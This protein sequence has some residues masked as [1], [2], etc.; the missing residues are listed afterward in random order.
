[1][2]NSIKVK[3]NWHLNSFIYHFFRTFFPINK[4]RII[5]ESEGDFTDNA[6]ALF[7]Y[8]Y[9][10]GYFNNTYQAF[11]LMDNPKHFNK[12]FKHTKILNKTMKKFNF[13]LM[14]YLA[15]S[16]DYIYDH[17]NLFENFK[18][19]P[20]QRI[21]YL[22]HGFGYKAPKGYIFPE[23]QG[24]KPDV[25]M[26]EGKIPAKE[27]S[28]WY[29]IDIKKTVQLGYPRNDY[30]LQNNSKIYALFCNDHYHFNTYNKVVLWMPTFRQSNI[31][32]L[33]ENY[34]SAGTGLPLLTSKEKL[35]EFNT[36]LK[37]K[38]VLLILKMHHLQANLEVF[39]EQFSNIIVIRDELFKK[40]G[41]QLY[42]F[43]SLADAL[44]TDYSSIS[45][46]FLL[47]D[48]PIIYTLDDYKE[49]QKSRGI[50]P[51]NALDLMRGY[52]VY[53]ITDL[54]IAINDIIIGKD[55]YKDDRNK[56]M[57]SL[58]EYPDGKASK[59]IVDYLGYEL[60]K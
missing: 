49:Y 50:T 38:N 41:I 56:I 5:F 36:Y 54:E 3:I 40:M 20:K 53:T 52:H 25:L 23:K 31:G 45:T 18:K 11:W 58:I 27:N 19:R 8:M 21:I 15:T 9:K 28:Q 46:D 10:S 29:D 24:S 1:M 33:S 12:K 43:V 16:K 60:I 55:K 30:L 35:I 42:Q 48:R 4:K 59:R 26:V 2:D 47:L 17:N 44:I 7:N 22:D 14:Y 6:Q 51:K 37:S 13:R 32:S 34:L 57:P 39:K